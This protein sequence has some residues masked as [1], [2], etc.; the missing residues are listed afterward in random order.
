MTS[1]ERSR[2]DALLRVP[3]ISASADH[4]PHMRTAAEMIA[5]ELRA[6][7]ADPEVRETAGQPLVLG[8]VP[9]SAGAA[10]APRVLIYGHY[11]VQP[12]GDPAL[13]T[14]PAFEPAERDGNLYARG[15]SDDK[16]NLFMLIAAV[17]RLAASGELPVHAAFVVD[18]E[19]ESGGDSAVAHLA[20]EA[21]RALACII[22]DSPMVAPGRPAICTGVRGL[23]GRRI[24]V[25][26]AEGDGHSGIYGGAALSAAHVLMA[27]LGAVTPR[28][29]RLPD[30]LYE[31]LAPAGA[32]EVAAWDA[33]PPGASA[34]ADAGLRPADAGAAEGFYARTLAGPS[35]DV[36]GL[37]CGDPSA[38]ATIVPGGAEA[39]LSL[40][41]A[42]GQDARRMAAAF[43]GLLRAAVPAG[44]DV[45]I[46][47]LGVALPAALDPGHPVLRAAARGIEA[48][49]GWPAAPV[50]LGGTL[51][52]VAT[53][54]AAGIPT[55]LSGFGLPTD[56]IHSPDE[57]I[58]VEYL[59]TGT[60]AAMAILTELGALSG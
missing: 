2:L 30:A 57:H 44:A 45:Q 50:R 59:E 52:V 3:S 20:A 5:S 32:A 15:A 17:Q 1:D 49:T 53:L 10:S 36:H 60:R 14:T 51:P 31:G 42:P 21:G 9:A 40:R 4:A 23:V 35:V 22:F 38:I 46:E 16:G 12:P 26:T 7:G 58:R 37:R 18:G 25:R 28:D 47:D 29:G 56:R 6:A 19:E 27:V 55:I 8:E 24:R 11:D 13:W 34:L 48:A 54:A 43:D 33:L 39:T 41:L